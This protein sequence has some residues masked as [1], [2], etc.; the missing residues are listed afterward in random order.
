MRSVVFFPTLVS[1]IGVGLTFTVLL[2]PDRGLVNNALALVGIG[3][4]GWLVCAPLGPD[5]GW[6]VR[7]I[8]FGCG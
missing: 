3:G 2:H 8:G 5:R 7:A 4:P 6:G 1:W